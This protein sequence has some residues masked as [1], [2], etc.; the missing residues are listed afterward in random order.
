MPRR[1]HQSGFS[2]VETMIATLLGLLVLAGA[3]QL[4]L[5][6]GRSQDRSEQLAERQQALVF[7]TDS[8]LRDIRVAKGWDL[9]ADG[10][11]ATSLRLTLEGSRRATYCPGAGTDDFTVTYAR[12][13]DD[14]ILDPGCAASMALV[15]GIAGFRVER[16]AG[17]HSARITMTLTAAQDA[18]SPTLTFTAVNRPMTIRN[19]TAD[20]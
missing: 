2:L 5:T 11:T 14:L 18:P 3:T 6:L 17:S 7:G 16:G 9:P 4:Y 8:L 13:D 15:S 1:H 19:A 20:D 10:M 12:Q